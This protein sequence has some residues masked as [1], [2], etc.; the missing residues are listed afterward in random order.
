MEYAPRFVEGAQACHIPITELS[1]SEALNLEPNLNPSILKAYRVPDGSFDPL[2]LALAFAAT[3]KQNG[4]K[5][6]TYTQAQKI[7]AN[8]KGAVSG[9]E[10]WDRTQN[11][12]YSISTDIVIN[13]T[14]A[15]AGNVAKL[16]GVNVPI[17]PTPGVMVAYDQ[18]LINHVINRLDEPCDGDILIPQRRMVVI[19]TT[20]FEVNDIDYIPVLEDQIKLMYAKAVEMVPAVARTSMR[21]A[22]MSARPL[23]AASLQGR[24]LSRTF[25]CYDHSDQGIEGL[26][27]ITG[28]KATTCRVMAEKIADLACQ[29]MSISATC[30]TRDVILTSYR[31]YYRNQEN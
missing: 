8:G 9:V 12:T 17:I 19:G 13:A 21:G 30:L 7:E 1:T 3:A 26:L 2:R 15:W 28:G 23:I 27:T 25:K 31:N 16:A 22:Y 24:S 10:V 6:L 5:F 4:S 20:S 11:K 14:G 18:R 29:K